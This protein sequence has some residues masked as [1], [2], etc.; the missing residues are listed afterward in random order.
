MCH[1]PNASLTEQL[2]DFLTRADRSAISAATL[3]R[4]KY[5][6]LDWLGSAIAGTRTEPGRIVLDYARRRA[7][8]RASVIGLDDTRSPEVA[9]FVN[10]ALSHIV[11][12]DDLHR[13]SVIHPA[14]VVVPAALACAEQAGATGRDLLV[15]I[16][17]GYEV[18]IRIGEAVGRSHYERWHSTGT[19]GTFGAAAAAGWLLKLDHQQMVWALG[20]AG[21]QAAG[22]WQFIADGAMT[23]HL[24]A[25]KAAANGLMAAELAHSGFT[26]PREILEGRQ[27][28]FSA[29]S[30]DARPEKVV[31]GLADAL[32]HP[33]IEG[34]SIKP[35]ASCRHTH[36]AI[37]AALRLRKVRTL[38]PREIATVRIQTYR[39]ALDVASNPAPSTPYAAKFS[40]QYC[41]ARALLSGS[42][43]LDD[44][45]I[46]RIQEVGL[47]AVLARTSV[48]LDED[49]D[50]RYP[51]EWPT[52]LVITLLDGATLRELVTLPKGDPENPLTEAELEEKFRRL[53][54]GTRYEA[55]IEDLL[56]HVR[57]MDEREDRQSSIF[58]SSFGIRRTGNP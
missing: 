26:G 14:T 44:F 6:F 10:G 55:R 18:A 54:A 5:Y 12:M 3:R 22:L 56:S 46:E 51:A 13:A 57:E 17:L 23:K 9:A 4:A 15:A 48:E 45:A 37:D 2:A 31:E 21:S 32:N 1:K 42:A 16:V 38:D 47:Q 27:G 50:H 53:V 7:G 36:S 11:E 58:T 49:L 40:I 20:N 35:Y 33:K 52:R 39:A 41:T 8:G 28:F 30:Q 43:G 34:V 29:T 24:H 25:G 19:C